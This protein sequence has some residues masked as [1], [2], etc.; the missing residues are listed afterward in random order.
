MPHTFCRV[1]GYDAGFPTWGDDDHSPSWAIC[2]CCGAE[3]GYEDAT[4]LGIEHHRAAWLAGGAKWFGPKEKPPEWDLGLQ[5]RN[6]GAGL[7]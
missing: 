5:L 7:P 4:P 2:D 6:I 3:W 1:C